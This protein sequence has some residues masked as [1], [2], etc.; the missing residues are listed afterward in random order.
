MKASRA[1]VRVARSLKH[2]QHHQHDAA[3]DR[4]RAQG[5]VDHEGDQDVDRRPRNVEGGDRHRPRQGLAHDVELAHALG[6]G[7]R[8]HGAHQLLQ[9]AA[10]Q[11]P[12]QAQARQGQ[13]PRAHRLQG[14]LGGQGE[15]DD[16]GQVQ[17]GQPALGGHDA[18]IDLH[19]VDG[20]RQ[21]QD[22][23][24]G[25]EHGRGQRCGRQARKAATSGGGNG[26]SRN[27]TRLSQAHY[28]LRQLTVAAD[29][30]PLQ[31]SNSAQEGPSRCLLDEYL[32]PVHQVMLLARK[33]L[34]SQIDER[35]IW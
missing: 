11:Q 16:Q 23:D 8:R 35:T 32:T 27:F 33:R 1:R 21:Q 20:R 18:V 29:L 19:H 25:A 4:H 9:D 17:Q 2:R 26:A 13:Q 5:R 22:V 14:R 34:N 10:G 15:G 24:Q 6:R 3:D 31:R 28:P 12:I 7:P 30:T